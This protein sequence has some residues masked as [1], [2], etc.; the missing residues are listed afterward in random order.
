MLLSAG[1][2][3]S[4][5]SESVHTAVPLAIT[6]ATVG[7]ATFT[8]P[9]GGDVAVGNGR[10]ARPS[11]KLTLDQAR[12]RYKGQYRLKPDRQFLLAIAYIHHFLT[13]KELQEV[14]TSFSDKYW[15]LRYADMD[16]GRL[17]ELADFDELYRLLLNWSQKLNTKYPLPLD[18][19]QSATMSAALGPARFAPSDL[20]I[21]LRGCNEKW[22][23]GEHA[24]ALLRRAT[25]A[26][27]RLSYQRLDLMQ[28]ADTLV[29]KAL[30]MM[31]LSEAVC[32]E[33]ETLNRC[34]IADAMEY[35]AYARNLSGKLE[36]GAPLRLYL[37]NDEM[38]LLKLSSGSSA[39]SEEASYL[40]AKMLARK[41]N[42]AKWKLFV[43]QHFSD[44]PA[45]TL[46]VLNTF[47]PLA[48]DQSLIPV[49]N[50]I[51]AESLAELQVSHSPKYSLTSDQLEWSSEL[52]KTALD[53]MM[54]DLLAQFERALVK[55]KE[56]EKI[57]K[58]AQLLYDPEITESYYF[59]CFS[60]SIFLLARAYFALP[61]QKVVCEDFAKSLHVQK[62]ASAHELEVWLKD[63]I[64]LKMQ[65]IGSEK[66]ANDLE[67]SEHLGAPALINI[68]TELGD[69]NVFDSPANV[70][71]LSKKLFARIDSRLCNR[72]SIAG[73]AD[74][75]LLDVNLTRVLLDSVKRNGLNASL[76][77]RAL[78]I[79]VADASYVRSAEQEIRSPKTDGDRRLKLLAY[80]QWQCYFKPK[81]DAK[82]R[83]FVD[84]QYRAQVASEPH[85]WFVMYN[86]AEF[87]LQF[88]EKPKA[89]DQLKAWLARQTTTT[90]SPA[91]ERRAR[92]LLAHTDYELKDYK[93]GLSALGKFRDDENLSCALQKTLL[94]NGLGQKKDAEKSMRELLD[95]NPN[96]PNV[97]LFAAAMFWSNQEYDEAAK[98]IKKGN[99]AY[100]DW[101]D[102]AAILT[103]TYLQE[104]QKI[105]FAVQALRRAGFNNE[106]NMVS[107][108][109]DFLGR[110]ELAFSIASIDLTDIP[111]N[112]SRF[113]NAFQCLK[114]WKGRKQ[115]LQWICNKISVNNRSA[116]AWEAFRNGQYELLWDFIPTQ[117]PNDDSFVWVLRAAA[118][119]N[120]KGLS[121]EY[122][123]QLKLHFSNGQDAESALGRFL[124]EDAK[125]IFTLP[126][127]PKEMCSSAFF[128]AWK[129]LR[130]GDDYSDQN[131]WLHVALETGAFRMVEYQQ[132][133]RWLKEIQQV[134]VNQPAMRRTTSVNKARIVDQPE[135]HLESPFN[136]G[137]TVHLE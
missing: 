14:D 13:Q 121:P 51:I 48:D 59:S 33:D 118:A 132:S 104:P 41:R 72:L 78:L 38:K 127:S 93:G 46:S 62:D 126:L 61:F 86:Y 91:V 19:A 88:R 11:E 98:V 123:K 31:A 112:H 137:A 17:S 81:I 26:L 76:Y 60:S 49:G 100:S 69:Y 3:K 94:I 136:P 37:N 24:E 55:S 40:S 130:R 119:V 1:C 97:V 15:H 9:G 117:L 68:F 92:C 122:Q 28:A 8:H 115:A 102:L 103:Q 99:L 116:L 65:R 20:L 10:S 110:S 50:L 52:S 135:G 107:E 29:G 35:S 22:Q 56:S 82:L 124:V 39:Q 27:V 79:S 109:V 111:A 89:R 96:N 108:K 129:G 18:Q 105:I 5:K 44:K 77:R 85:N 73:I 66:L 12:D 58:S 128:I 87:L 71:T 4:Q 32:K 131:A 2:T 16:V 106:I 54:S 95:Q 113:V 43:V 21:E 30:S 53:W 34:F 75:T 45:M 120:N 67:N 64:A 63:R 7:T 90:M 6:P 114:D 36:A 133:W 83:G 101:T 134:I 80:L 70:I 42:R 47:L 57:Y 25:D 125:D 84:E 74:G 23:N